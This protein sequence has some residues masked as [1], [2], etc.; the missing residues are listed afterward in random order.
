MLISLQ[1]VN[2]DAA[3]VEIGK[4]AHYV[5]FPQVEITSQCASS[6]GQAVGKAILRRSHAVTIGL[7]RGIKE[8]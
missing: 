2:P 7:Q 4:E 6:G 8:L 1:V 5:A 3:G